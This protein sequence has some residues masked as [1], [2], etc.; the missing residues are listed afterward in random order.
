M[1]E[2]VDYKEIL[3]KL[4]SKK[5]FE[6]LGRIRIANPILGSQLEAYLVQLYEAGQLQGEIDDNK[7][8]QILKVITPK[9]R[10]TKIK[11]K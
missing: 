8:K 9:K 1:K 7:L 2:H 5:A 6:R 3:I 4:L 10:K 11:R